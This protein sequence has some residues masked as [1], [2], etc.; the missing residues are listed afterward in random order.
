MAPSYALCGFDLLVFACMNIKWDKNTGLLDH[1]MDIFYTCMIEVWHS[2]GA[3]IYV[4]CKKAS[5]FSMKTQK[6][7]FFLLWRR[8]TGDVVLDSHRDEEDPGL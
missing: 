7:F 2:S 5:L 6:L 1:K 3:R 4:C 8:Q